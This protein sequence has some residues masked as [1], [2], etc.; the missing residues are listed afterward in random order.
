MTDLVEMATERPHPSEYSV[1]GITLYG[2]L[3]TAQVCGGLTVTVQAGASGETTPHQIVLAFGYAHR[4]HCYT[5][6]EPCLFAVHPSVHAEEARGC[7]FG[8]GYRMWQVDKLDRTIQIMTN[9]DTFDELVLQRSAGGPRQ[10]LTYA[11]KMQMLHRG[12][13]LTD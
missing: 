8:E 5:F 12:G 4:G 10:P 1:S 11:A 2:V 13:R 9:S 3:A 7:G 6:P